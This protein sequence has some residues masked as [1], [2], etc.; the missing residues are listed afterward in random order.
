[1]SILKYA[2]IF[3]V[4]FFV[5]VLLYFRRKKNGNTES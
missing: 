2:V 1:M 5:G 3:V 4:A